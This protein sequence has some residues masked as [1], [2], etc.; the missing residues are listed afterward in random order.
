MYYHVLW[1]GSGNDPNGN[2]DNNRVGL[3]ISHGN[4]DG[5]TSVVYSKDGYY[6]KDGEKVYL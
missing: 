5:T 1:E 6:I 2:M 4:L 3:K